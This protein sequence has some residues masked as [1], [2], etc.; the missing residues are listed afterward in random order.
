M[1]TNVLATNALKYINYINEY[2][3]YKHFDYNLISQIQYMWATHPI[4]IIILTI[5]T[6]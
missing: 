2:D 1:K 6:N 5:C 3:L 4:K